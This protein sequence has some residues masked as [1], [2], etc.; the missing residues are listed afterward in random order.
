M[1]RA[2]SLCKLIL[3]FSLLIFTSRFVDQSHARLFVEIYIR[4]CDKLTIFSKYARS[5]W[6]TGSYAPASRVFK[7]S[8]VT[9]PVGTDWIH[10][11]KKRKRE[12]LLPFSHSVLSR[13]VCSDI[14]QIYSGGW[15]CWKSIFHAVELRGRG[16]GVE[17]NQPR[18]QGVYLVNWEGKSPGIEFGAQPPYRKLL[19]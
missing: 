14:S 8:V 19:T 16:G 17:L 5:Y 11:G 18:S 6:H 9:S 4:A 15:R 1:K 12:R 10:V 2:V 13:D 3:V 7:I